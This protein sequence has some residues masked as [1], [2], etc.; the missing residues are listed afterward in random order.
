MRSQHSCS[1]PFESDQSLYTA[2]SATPNMVGAMPASKGN[3]G[4]LVLSGP[5]V[6]R[7]RSNRSNGNERTLVSQAAPGRKLPTVS[8]AARARKQRA[9]GLVSPDL[10]T[11]NS[12]QF[13]YSELCQEGRQ[14]IRNW[15]LGHISGVNC[16]LQLELCATVVKLLENACRTVA[17][18]EEEAFGGEAALWTAGCMRLGGTD[19]RLKNLRNDL[20]TKTPQVVLQDA[21]EAVETECAAARDM[22]ELEEVSMGLFRLCKRA[23][24]RAWDPSSYIRVQVWREVISMQLGVTDVPEDDGGEAT[25]A[26]VDDETVLEW[27]ERT[28]DEARTAAQNLTP[29][30]LKRESERLLEYAAKIMQMG[31]QV[32][33]AMECW[34]RFDPYRLLGV[35]RRATL[36]QIKKAFYKKALVLHPDKGGDKAA[37]QELQRA[38]DEIVSERNKNPQGDGDPFESSD[39]EKDW[40]EFR[41]NPNQPKSPPSTARASPKATPR[42]QEPGETPREAGYNDDSSD[43]MQ[44]SARSTRSSKAA[45]EEANENVNEDVRLALTQCRY[46]SGKATAAATRCGE[47]AVEVLRQCYLAVEALEQDQPDCEQACAHMEPALEVAG[48]VK[49]LAKET[50]EHMQELLE[51]LEQST[52]VL[53]ILDAKTAENSKSADDS[54]SEESSVAEELIDTVGD[55]S[56]NLCDS[57]K[58][59][60]RTI[61]GTFAALACQQLE[62]DSDDSA[63][64]GQADG[65]ADAL[66]AA[67]GKLITQTKLLAVAALE[68]AT[69]AGSALTTIRRAHMP[70]ADAREHQLAVVQ[71]VAEGLDAALELSQIFGDEAEEVPGVQQQK[72]AADAEEC[73]D[74]VLEALRMLRITNLELLRLRREAR[75]LVTK[76]AWAVPQ[77]TPE[78]EERAFSLFAEFLDQAALAFHGDLMAAVQSNP[79][80]FV[81][82]VRETVLSAIARSFCFLLRSS[83]A[84]A[85]PFEGRSQTLRAAVAV[86]AHQVREMVVL[87]VLPR[88]EMSVTNALMQARGSGIADTMPAA[89]VV[90]PQVTI[91]LHSAGKM[92]LDAITAL[93]A[94]LADAGIAH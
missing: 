8:Q 71:P 25:S 65:Q 15:A 68:A 23:E 76:D 33:K 58:A 2:C 67:V 18:E 52:E 84:L 24:R 43:D 88:L 93:E 69:A 26:E 3:S 7:V 5:A 77:V 1:A 66:H 70:E 17:E 73:L 59:Y 79:N 80:S 90:D 55:A 50:D 48:S 78:R 36:A 57:V 47:V 83:A 6:S 11:W 75:G 74:E 64:D 56:D 37:F 30:Q 32:R 29:E 82:Q 34:Q 13:V 72:G 91:A 45:Q 35:S 20:E 92:L 39:E 22:L 21:W 12:G 86:N 85:M 60:T 61:A 14:C 89:E 31:A 4:S 28:D 19:G 42:P 27:M 9:K 44:Q 40:T 41:W 54:G 38:Y 10:T 87:Q 62:P 94:G 81:C 46:L 16:L 51:V 53:R 49:E 63:S